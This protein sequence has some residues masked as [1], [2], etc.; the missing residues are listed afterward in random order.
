MTEAVDSDD[1]EDVDSDLDKGNGNKARPK[2]T[3][4]VELR[5]ESSIECTMKTLSHPYKR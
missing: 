5:A 4:L 2:W 1:V 3:I